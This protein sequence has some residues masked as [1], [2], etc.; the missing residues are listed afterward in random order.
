MVKNVSNKVSSD[1][2]EIAALK[3][4]VDALKAGPI[5][6]KV[7]R[8]KNRFDAA[9]GEGLSDTLCSWAASSTIRGTAKGEIAF[10][11]IS[12]GEGTYT[13]TAIRKGI[14]KAFEVAPSAA[15]VDTA[16]A[17]LEKGF[18]LRTLVGY[19]LAYDAQ[20]EQVVMSARKR[21]APASK[22]PRAARKALPA[23]TGDGSE[24]AA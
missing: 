14:A 23:P 19:T 15:Q 20:G 21:K 10:W 5:A 9:K 11:L 7:A 3:A 24:N 18:A 13:N 4:Q 17:M 1:S 22:A 6:A 12:R 16:L 2:K 8:S